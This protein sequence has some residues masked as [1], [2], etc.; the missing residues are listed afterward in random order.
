MFSFLWHIFFFSLILSFFFMPS[1]R[2]QNSFTTTIQ[3]LDVR[4]ILIFVS[5]LRL[6]CLRIFLAIPIDCNMIP[7]L[8]QIN[9]VFILP[10]PIFLYSYSKL[11][12]FKPSKRTQDSFTTIIQILDVLFI[13]IFISIVIYTTLFTLTCL[14]LF[15]LTYLY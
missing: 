9:F 3:I 15:T 14:Y 13:F 7:Y 4:V 5:I 8:F 10:V 11:F 12:V 2:I 6:Y 1:K